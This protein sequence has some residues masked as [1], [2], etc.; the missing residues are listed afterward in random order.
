[1]KKAKKLINYACCLKKTKDNKILT[2][3]NDQ[4][5]KRKIDI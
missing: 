5:E 2:I 3:D 1:M 4:K